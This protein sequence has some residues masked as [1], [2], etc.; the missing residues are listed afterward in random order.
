MPEQTEGQL[1]AKLKPSSQ[2]Y[3]PDEAVRRMTGYIDAELEFMQHLAA[4]EEV[5]AAVEQALADNPVKK[6]AYIHD[7]QPSNLR[8]PPAAGATSF[9]KALPAGAAADIAVQD[10]YQ[11]DPRS[12]THL[13]GANNMGVFDSTL[14]HKPGLTFFPLHDEQLYM[15]F[16]HHVYQGVTQWQQLHTNQEDKI[17]KLAAHMAYLRAKADHVEGGS[18]GKLKDADVED[19]HFKTVAYVLYQSKSLVVSHDLLRKFDIQFEH[20]RVSAGQAITGHGPHSGF[21]I[22]D[23][24]GVGHN[25]AFASNQI[26]EQWLF[27][28]ITKLEEHFLWLQQLAE[29][30]SHTRD[31]LMRLQGITAAMMAKALHQSPHLAL[32]TLLRRLQAD[33]HKHNEP[34]HRHQHTCKRIKNLRQRCEA[35]RKILHSKE[36]TALM[37]EFYLKKYDGFWMCTK[38]E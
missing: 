8:A 15:S 16:T 13:L 27:R 11:H 1:R 10:D 22:G 20:A 19:L 23:S 29:M 32:C 36:V 25:V 18:P 7:A 24:L 4:G 33:H 21:S 9:F 5:P 6:R 3:T 17:M 38:C 35:L 28:G 2:T 14:F 34:V 31:E 37:K 12:L 26:D 30:G